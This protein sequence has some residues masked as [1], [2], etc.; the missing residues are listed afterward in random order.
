MHE[1]REKTKLFIKFIYS[2]KAKKIYEISTF[3]WLYIGQKLGED[4]ANF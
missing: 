2:E 4:F 3:D 1:N